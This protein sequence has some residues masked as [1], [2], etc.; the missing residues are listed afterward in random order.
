M[1]LLTPGALN[2][3]VIMVS[4]L[5][6]N[7]WWKSATR[8]KELVKTLALL[9]VKFL[10]VLPTSPLGNLTPSLAADRACA[11]G[12]VGRLRSRRW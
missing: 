5:E 3:I 8:E 12:H 10:L 2:I 1:G 7:G 11:P 4:P 9:V 6:N